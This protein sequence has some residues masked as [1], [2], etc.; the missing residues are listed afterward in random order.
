MLFKYLPPE[1]V[2]VLENLRIRFSPLR[3]LNDPFESMPLVD[4]TEQREQLVQETLQEL[5]ELW[6]NAHQDD[7]TDDN[8]RQ[9]EEARA[10]ALELIDRRLD[11][12][13]VGKSLID[14][15]GSK[16]G[17]LSLCR[18]EVSLLMWSHYTNEGKGFVIGFDD[19]HPFFQELS[20]S[21]RPTG[22]IPIVYSMKR[23]K[24]SN[25]DKRFYERLLCEKPIDWSYEEEERVFRLYLSNDGSIGKDGYA[26]EIFLTELPKEVIQSVYIGYRADSSLVDALLAALDNHAIDCQVYKSQ[27]S[28]NEYKIKFEGLVRA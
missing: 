23:N 9:L 3:S 5:D 16:L 8:F 26:Q 18:T 4:T 2:D 7:K 10:G 1:R 14:L 11:S 17:I 6:T 27:I 25:Q 22:P 21:N 28:Q 13:E 24:V 20:A 15:I 12:A 19:S